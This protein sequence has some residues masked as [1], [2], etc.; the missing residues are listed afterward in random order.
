MPYDAGMSQDS[1][2]MDI[3][4]ET[5]LAEG[6]FMKD[7]IL[8]YMIAGFSFAMLFTCVGIALVPIY[9]VFALLIGPKVIATWR[10]TLTNRA[11][12]VQ[13]GLLVKVKK[14]VPLEKI[15][16]VGSVQGPIMRKFGIH[17]LTFETAGQSG[18]GA[19]ISLIGLEDAEKFRDRILDV[20]DQMQSGG[21]SGTASAQKQD[22]AQADQSDILSDIRDS[23]LRIEKKL[24]KD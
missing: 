21:K 10:C 18:P 2:D 12:H 7:Q 16:D 13:K 4:N 9:A 17:K 22:G 19:L 3:R 5:V 8:R 6:T 20:R 23:L 11:V 15:T 14:T 24:D 1:H